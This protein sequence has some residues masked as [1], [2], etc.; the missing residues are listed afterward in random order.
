MKK[1][2]LG[3]AFVPVVGAIGLIYLLLPIAHVILFSFNEKRGRNN[4]IW[5]GFTLA[6]WQ[7][8]CGAPQVCTAFGN[9][10]MVGLV[11][12]VIATV[13][14]TM[15]AIALVRYRFKFRSTIS[16]LLFTPMATPEVVLGAGLAAQF[17]LAG[18]EKGLGTV[19]LA[20]VMFCISYV[21][22]A[23]KARVASL[24]PA[25]EEAGRDLYASPGQV[26]WRITLPMLMPGIIGAALL[27]FALSFDDFII[28]NFNSG[29]AT[30]FPKFI[31]VSALKGVPAQANVLASI[32]LIGALL[33]VIIVQS[34]NISRQKKLATR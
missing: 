9:S 22:V 16:L 31:Y 21:V 6:N 28:T 26:F 7:N 33:L 15:I 20:H 8:P 23:V 29:T 17:L 11:S 25:I 14:G 4:I 18:V 24:N 5:N 13:L 30:T 1:F 2:S 32:V 34:V 10:I 19:I 27:S 12:T 3:K